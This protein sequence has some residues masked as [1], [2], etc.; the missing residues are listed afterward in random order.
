MSHGLK[1]LKN[2]L[3]L[4]LFFCCIHSSTLTKQWN[5]H[6]FD[7]YV[8]GKM[9]IFPAGKMLLVFGVYIIF[10]VGVQ[11]YNVAPG[12]C[13]A[14]SQNEVL[15]KISLKMDDLKA[16]HFETY[17]YVQQARTDRIYSIYIIYKYTYIGFTPGPQ[18]SRKTTR[19]TLHFSRESQPK[20]LFA[21]VTG[22]GVDP[23]YI[24]TEI[25]QDTHINSIYV[26]IPDLQPTYGLISPKNWCN[27]HHEGN[28]A[29]SLVLQF[30]S[31]WI[32]RLSKSDVFFLGRIP[33]PF[34]ATFG[35]FSGRK[36]MSF[37]PL[38][39]FCCFTG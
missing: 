10:L 13:D 34:G 27:F 9:G 6:H 24:Y 5:I 30:T 4:G 36:L 1:S 20:P 31:P 22:W 37:H 15:P 38:A 25:F 11:V 35:K 26:N 8:P 32:A 14:V 29:L 2:S 17:P 23:I 39:R 18:D 3:W 19:L 21:S 7:G 33:L 12:C 28:I 16:L